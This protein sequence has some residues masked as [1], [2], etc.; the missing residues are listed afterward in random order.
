MISPDTE[1]PP[2]EPIL[3]S[4]AFR[5]GI[6]TTLGVV[7]VPLLGLFDRNL[8]PLGAIASGLLAFPVVVVIGAILS[9][10]RST[11]RF[12]LGLLLADAFALLVLVAICGGGVVKVF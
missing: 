1:P 7:G 4:R 6:L 10:P 8:G 3:K 5:S 9:V 11:R 12:A 2:G